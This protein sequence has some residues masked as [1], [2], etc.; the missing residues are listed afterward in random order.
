MTLVSTLSCSEGAIL[1]ADTQETLGNYSKRKIDKISLWQLHNRPFRFG[2]AD[3]CTHGS[4]S[5]MLK[6]ELSVALNSVDEFD[7]RKFH[8]A[9]TV[10]VTDF[11]GKHI[12][13]RTDPNTP[14]MEFLIVIQPLPSGRPE[15]FHVSE[16]AVN[17]IGYTSQTS[18][19]GIG[20][21]LADYLYKRLWTP[22]TLS[23]MIALAVYVGREVHEHVDGV[24]EVERIA[25]FD[26][27]GRYDEVEGTD[28]RIIERN[29]EL[30]NHL[31]AIMLESALS[32]DEELVENAKIAVEWS[33]EI[34]AAYEKWYTEWLGRRHRRE[35][36]RK[37]I[38]SEREDNAASS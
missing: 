10:T 24:G 13:K 27:E 26:R 32:K 25:V 29:L 33:E 34:R 12:W 19:I 30:A 21:H 23:Q 35:L 18:S 16:T 38:E 7:L 8:Q 1:F 31:T 36:F 15:S 28:M 11:Y 2:I 22:Q 5:D 14:A 4:Y 9:L 20:A 3:A 17:A 37:A 6:S